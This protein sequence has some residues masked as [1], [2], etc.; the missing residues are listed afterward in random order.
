[1]KWSAVFKMAKNVYRFFRRGK[2]SSY[3]SKTKDAQVKLAEDFGTFFNQSMLRYDEMI[4]AL[5]GKGKKDTDFETWQEEIAAAALKQQTEKKFSMKEFFSEDNIKKFFSKETAKTFTD[6]FGKALKE[7]VNKPKN[8]FNKV[9]EKITGD[10]SKEK[11]KEITDKI[12]GI[13][14]SVQSAITKEKETGEIRKD[15][16]NIYKDTK[17]LAKD[18]YKTGKKDIKNIYKD[19]K[20]L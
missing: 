20:K 4:A 3:L 13:K 7:E 17:V 11:L 18:K 16:K 15:I 1:M 14:N 2:Y 9:K 5:K 10:S 12:D 19:T 6:E 8:M